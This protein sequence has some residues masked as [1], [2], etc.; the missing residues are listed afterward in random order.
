MK[1]QEKR[2]ALTFVP[3]EE[4]DAVSVYLREIGRIPLL[5]AE[6][7]VCLAQQIEAGRVELQKPVSLRDCLVIAAGEE[8]RRHFIEAN[9]RLVV[10]QVRGYIEYANTVLTF[11]D[12]VQEGNIGLLNAI[13]H[14]DY[15]R[16][17]K[18]ST[19]ATHWIRQAL[20]RARDNQSRLVRIPVH[21]SQ[22]LYRIRRA[23]ALHTEQL[24]AAPTTEEIAAQVDLSPETVLNLLSYEYQLISLEKSILG[25]EEQSLGSLLASTS[26]D[27]MADAVAR[28]LLADRVREAI[29]QAGLTDREHQ[30]IHLRWLSDHER[31]LSEVAEI[32]TP[33]IT[34]ERIRQIEE[35]AFRK[36][37][38]FLRAVA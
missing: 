1:T 7:E 14:F 10:S 13:E 23:I 33:K 24:G 9:L 18:F 2:E 36:L 29:Y 22:K 3:A 38:P 17:Y 37:R 8:A 12:L 11:E 26:V 21:V 32:I 5:S 19:C 30:V 4:N 35:M 25:A 15:R 16:G 6:E 31:T 27:D 28:S 20:G 34:R